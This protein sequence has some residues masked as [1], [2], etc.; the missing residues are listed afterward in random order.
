MMELY[1]NAKRNSI[2]LR[3]QKE[4]IF[5]FHRNEKIFLSGCGRDLVDKFQCIQYA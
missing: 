2:K 5:V 1:G 3:Q 4:K